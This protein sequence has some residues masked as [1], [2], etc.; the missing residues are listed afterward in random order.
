MVFV[1]SS[2]RDEQ[3]CQP[4]MKLVHQKD[5]EVLAAIHKATGTVRNTA[6]YDDAIRCVLDSSS[7]RVD[8]DDM[9][10][11]EVFKAGN[12]DVL[13]TINYERRVRYIW[14]IFGDLPSGSAVPTFIIKHLLSFPRLEALFLLSAKNESSTA[15][16]ISGDM[17]FPSTLRYL[18]I[19]VCNIDEA[20]LETLLFEVWPKSP[21]IL[22][23][24][25]DV[26]NIKSFQ[27]L[28]R[29]LG[30]ANKD[31][32]LFDSGLL[33]LSL[34]CAN[35]T[36][37]FEDSEE[38]TAVCDFLCAVPNV[39]I[40]TSNLSDNPTAR[41]RIFAE[42]S[43]NWCGRCL[44]QGKGSGRPVPLS[45]W[46]TLLARIKRDWIVGSYAKGCWNNASSLFYFLRNGPILAGLSSSDPTSS[47]KRRVGTIV[48]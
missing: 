22:K 35:K 21:N 23:F 41:E 43:L 24:F 30:K 33:K 46:P 44:L 3:P 45:I 31:R 10:S 36:R 6:E 11:P 32:F 39:L 37:L 28:R 2:C 26:G 48:V 47:K 27:F 18:S 7:H 5:Q 14:F 9:L 15:P 40:L 16:F 42:S 25:L 38:I 12:H 4:G 34:A 8:L 29:R 1:I 17:C 19:H 13:V 20:Q